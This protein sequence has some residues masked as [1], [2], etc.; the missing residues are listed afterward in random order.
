MEE[1]QLNPIPKSNSKYYCLLFFLNAKTFKYRNLKC[2]QILDVNKV[3]L[4]DFVQFA[5]LVDSM[6]KTKKGSEPCTACTVLHEI[7]SMSFSLIRN[8]YRFVRF[9]LHLLHVFPPESDAE[10][11]KS[12]ELFTISKPV[13][14]NI[15]SFSPLLVP[16]LG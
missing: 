7:A 16:I 14:S 9:P 15:F 8:V 5:Y 11:R 12:Q 2:A 6:V 3:N 10:S 1:N 13:V 4:E